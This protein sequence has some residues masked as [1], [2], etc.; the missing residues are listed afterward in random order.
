MVAAMGAVLPL[1]T[2]GATTTVRHH[3]GSH[4]QRP[5]PAPAIP[6]GAH[7]TGLLAKGTRLHLAVGLQPRDPATLAAFAAAVT[8]PGNPAYHHYLRRGAFARVFGP[9]TATISTVE[10]AFSQAGFSIGRLDASHLS[11]EVS[12]PAGT[13][14]RF[15]H[16]SFAT[17]TLAGGTSGYAITSSPTLA[18][19]VRGEVTS[20][21]GLTT[22]DRQHA[23][24]LPTTA[25]SHTTARAT[26]APTPC[27]TLTNDI[28]GQN[29]QGTFTTDQLAQAYGL[30]SQY[31]NGNFGQG[32]TIG[33]YELA[34][35][36]SSDVATYD[37]C[38]GVSP[39]IKNVNIDGGP[40][41]GLSGS[42]CQPDAEPTLDI[43]EI[44]SLA[45]KATIVVYQSNQNGNAANDL[46][47]AIADDDAAQ[48]VSYSWGGCEQQDTGAY[49]TAW[50]ATVLE[51]MAAQGQTVVAASGD[52]GASD[53]WTTG[54][55]TTAS[56]IEQAVDDPG[57][58][59][60]VTS[61]GGTSTSSVNPLAET[62]W[63]DGIGGGAGGGGPSN[64]WGLPWWQSSVAAAEPAGIATPARMV[65]DVSF[66]ADPNTGVM[67]YQQ[68]WSPIGGTSAAAPL[69]A[70]IVALADAH[71]HRSLGFINPALYELY[72]SNPSDF[73]D[74]TSGTNALFSSGARAI[75]YTASQ[76]YDLASGLGSTTAGFFTDICAAPSAQVTSTNA[77][78]GQVTTL[79]VTTTAPT[80]LAA[81]TALSLELPS[82]ASFPVTPTLVVTADGAPIG[83]SALSASTAS[84]TTGTTRLRFVLNAPIAT[85]ATVVVRVPNVLNPESSGEVG[86]TDGSAALG[87]QVASASTDFGVAGAL[88]LTASTTTT[89]A[90]PL[91][92]TVLTNLGPQAIGSL[93][94]TGG[95]TVGVATTS[96]SHQL[97]L[98][99]EQRGTWTTTSL[100][101]KGLNTAAG[102]P[103]P[104]DSLSL[105]TN[106]TSISTISTTGHVLA[107]V[108]TT[109]GGPTTATDLTASTKTPVAASATSTCSVIVGATGSSRVVVV[110]RLANGSLEQYT[111]R[112]Q[113]A[114]PFTATVLTTGTGTPT[115]TTSGSDVLVV[116]RTTTGHAAVVT[117]STGRTTVVD[118]TTL[119]GGSSLA[120]DPTSAEVVGTTALIGVRFANGH[121]G[122]L[123]G[124]AGRFS[125]VDLTA[126]S[127]AGGSTSPF[128]TGS[129]G[130][131]EAGAVTAAGALTMIVQGAGGTTAFNLTETK[132]LP[133]LSNLAATPSTTAIIVAGITQAG[134]LDVVTTP[135]LG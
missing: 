18:Q 111:S 28:S 87:S 75:G 47:S 13:V 86:L 77:S 3:G 12:A 21:L 64:V 48:V 88:P 1:C 84:G 11:L 29:D 80:Q 117:E 127:G 61:V 72:A 103:G 34:P 6:R 97:A 81:G 57:S 45:P 58:Q 73:Y 23:L 105:A 25:A 42:S 38:Y 66:N 121:L 62:V 129:P 128:L 122:V 69:F 100:A 19:A 30:T 108:A 35:Y 82:G 54:D 133:K 37:Q 70:A 5:I 79:S 101:L 49:G 102:K 126:A 2:A 43:E 78:A 22:L 55:P 17:Y 113:G 16:T 33:L 134:H 92:T 132:G 41:A 26:T 124:T 76:G 60:F 74:V 120:N 53:C 56:N 51:Q 24:G 89:S 36:L 31:A 125:Q 46:F 65:P 123:T 99:L 15:F 50:E 67:I 68:G 96:A 116:E 85:G 59:P 44:A 90:T 52:D 39:T 107:L 112:T 94:S 106:L 4:R 83:V 104:T 9:T 114:G 95:T 130:A 27:S 109:L 14:A 7:R 20:I 40:C 93:S 8:E 119:S 118:A 135:R 10:H 91:P 131:L 98:S 71:C 32:E 115:C 110:A 63:N